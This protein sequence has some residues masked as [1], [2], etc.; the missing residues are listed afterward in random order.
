MDAKL[1]CEVNVEGAVGTV[2][3]MDRGEERTSKGRR[4]CLRPN[5]VTAH[6]ARASFATAHA[7]ACGY[8]LHPHWYI[9]LTRCSPNQI[10]VHIFTADQ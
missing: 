9:T 6:S 10:P 4:P 7:Q 3:M 5:T 1:D 2:D 8:S